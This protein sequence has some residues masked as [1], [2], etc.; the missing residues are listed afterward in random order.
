MNG[1]KLCDE[2]AAALRAAARS[3]CWVVLPGCVA[4]LCCRAKWSGW[5]AGL[6][7]CAGPLLVSLGSG[8]PARLP[9]ARLRLGVVDL[10]AR[11]GLAATRCHRGHALQATRYS[12]LEWLISR[13]ALALPPPA[14]TA[15]WLRRPR[16]PAAWPSDW[17]LGAQGACKPRGAPVL[18]GV[19]VLDRLRSHSERHNLSRLLSSIRIGSLPATVRLEPRGAWDMSPCEASEWWAIGS[20][21]EGAALRGGF[22]TPMGYVRG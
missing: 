15:A 7:G 11:P 22:C 18:G 2:R 9:H 12:G 17:L 5:D 13:F 21:G 19:C 10:E 6:V 20:L 1:P 8:P 4:G 14:A 16:G 3:C